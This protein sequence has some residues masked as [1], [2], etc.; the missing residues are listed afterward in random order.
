[1]SIY[2]KIFPP[3]LLTLPNGKTGFQTQI[4]CSAGS[5]DFGCYDDPFGGGHRL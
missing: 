4:S 2:D 1:M 5:S 3:K